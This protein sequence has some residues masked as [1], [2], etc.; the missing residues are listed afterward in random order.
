MRYK[1]AIII[2]LFFLFSTFFICAFSETVSAVAKIELLEDPTYDLYFSSEH[3]SVYRYYINLT[4]YNSGDENTEPINIRLFE[5]DKA[6]LAPEGIVNSTTIKV[7]EKL[8]ITFNWVT[9]QSYETVEIKWYPSDLKSKSDRTNSGNVT[10]DISSV[11]IENEEGIPGFE[12]V[13]VII[14]LLFTLI[15]IKN[16]RK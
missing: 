1:I 10:L 8:N 16:R 11:P 13:S 2:S 3:P 4:L 7:G 6:S 9:A 12:F 15:L 5:N 14:V